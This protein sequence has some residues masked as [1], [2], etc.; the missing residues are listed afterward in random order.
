MAAQQVELKLEDLWQVA[1]IVRFLNQQ[2]ASKLTQGSTLKG[3]LPVLLGG[4]IDAGGTFHAGQMGL[5]AITV[6]DMDTPSPQYGLNMDHSRALAVRSKDPYDWVPQ[7]RTLIEDRFAALS[8]VQTVGAVALSNVRPYPGCLNCMR[9]TTGAVLNNQAQATLNLQRTA[10]AFG[11]GLGGN[12]GRGDG[13]KIWFGILFKNTDA[14]LGFMELGVQLYDQ[15]T[16]QDARFRVL[17]PSGQFMVQVPGGGYVNVGGVNTIDT[18]ECWHWMGM[19]LHYQSGGATLAYQMLRF[20]DWE[21]VLSPMQMANNVGAAGI[22]RTTLEI[23]ATNNAAAVEICDV[24]FVLYKDL[25]R[26]SGLLG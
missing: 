23:T 15:A 20:D 6:P 4:S 14:N 1:Q 3:I 13:P 5:G 2:D 18:T 11:R 16:R 9:L 8:W 21:V 19:E 22:N 10:D 25:T 7:G 17:Y 26:V 12:L 24:G